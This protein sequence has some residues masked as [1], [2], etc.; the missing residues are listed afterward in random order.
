MCRKRVCFPENPVQS[1]ILFD[2]TEAREHP[3]RIWY[4]ETEIQFIKERNLALIRRSRLYG[5]LEETEA[6]TFLGLDV[7]VERKKSRWKRNQI[8][9]AVFSEQ[10][11]QEIGP[12]SPELLADVVNALALLCCDSQMCLTWRRQKRMIAGNKS[13]RQRS[14]FSTNAGSKLKQGLPLPFRAIWRAAFRNRWRL[15][16]ISTLTVN[17]QPLPQSFAPS[18][19]GSSYKKMIHASIASRFGA[20]TRESIAIKLHYHFTLPDFARMTFRAT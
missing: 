9:E 10:S 1:V 3:A 12:K 8:Y 11:R 6:E 5:P 16:L 19:R 7:L 15:N 14:L 13:I 17:M 4:S 20:S 2:D 18:T